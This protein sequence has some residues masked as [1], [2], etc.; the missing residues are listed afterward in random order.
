MLQADLDACKKMLTEKD[1]QLLKKRVSS[2]S[3]PYRRPSA[4]LLLPRFPASLLALQ[5]GGVLRRLSTSRPFAGRLARHPLACFL[6]HR[7]GVFLFR[8]F[9]PQRREC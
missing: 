5:L 9:R 7:R 4:P 6:S 3:A 8:P 2:R 1:Y